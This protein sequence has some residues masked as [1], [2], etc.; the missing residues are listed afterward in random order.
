MKDRGESFFGMFLRA[1][2]HAMTQPAGQSN[3]G[4]V[5]LLA[6]LFDKNRALSLKRIMAKQF[7]D[8][9]GA[10]DIFNGPDGS[11]LIT[12]RNKVALDVLKT[13]LAEGNKK[14]AIFYGAGHMSDMAQRLTDEFHMKRKN[15]RW[16]TAWDLRA[17]KE[18]KL[19]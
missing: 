14:V 8:M 19:P 17:E 15:T 1:M 11:T 5:Q 2:G 10:M 12:E 6:A 18:K 13:R 4:D 16:L 9:G 3:V 7:Q